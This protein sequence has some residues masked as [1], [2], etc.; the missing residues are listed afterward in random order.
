V[1]SLDTAGAI[2]RALDVFADPSL[3]SCKRLE[4]YFASAE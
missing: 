1:T 4:E 2:V 3:A